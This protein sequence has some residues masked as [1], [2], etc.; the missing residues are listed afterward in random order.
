MADEKDKKLTEQSANEKENS[1]N[2]ADK[3]NRPKPGD[4]VESRMKYYIIAGAILLVIV[5]ALVVLFTP[6]GEDKKPAPEKSDVTQIEM[7]PLFQY[8]V[9][10]DD[11][12][13]DS[14][15]ATVEELKSEYK[16]RVDFD[17]VDV[18]EN[19]DSASALLAGSYDKT[20][21]LIMYDKNGSSVAIE[22]TDEK[23][24]LAADIEQAIA[25]K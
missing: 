8:Y 2:R 3:E 9:S 5:V 22:Y 18:D 20:P 7:T 16:D 4:P 14:Y 24:K 12:N 15:M 25:E 6:S 13:Y 11:E 17:I 19:A 23:E 1:K 21:I 10:K